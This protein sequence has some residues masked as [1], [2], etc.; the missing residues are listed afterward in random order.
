MNAV[1]TAIEP[2]LHKVSRQGAVVFL[3]RGAA[4]LL[5]ITSTILLSRLLGTIGLGKFQLGS[6]VVQLV[7]GFCLLGLDKALLRYVPILE[8]R[9]KTWR[10]LLIRGSSLVFVISLVLSAVLLLAAPV[11]ATSYFDSPEMTS[12]IRIFSFQIPVLVLFGFL[13]EAVTAAKRFDFASKIT[14]IFSPAVFVFLLTLVALVAPSL[15]GT[16]AARI[17]AQL[18]AVVCLAVLLVRHY[19][20]ISGVKPAERGIFKSYLRLSVPLFVIGLGY[21]VLNQMDT[22]MLGHFVSAKEVGIYSVSFKWFFFCL[23]C[24]Y[25]C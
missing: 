14:N 20:K 7:T 24:M 19:L 15:K 9:G 3:T 4:F 6:V 25:I 12:V 10:S 8:A 5:G 13:S 23:L 17:V 18:A 1:S 16:I 11:L 2:M 22:I 21:Q